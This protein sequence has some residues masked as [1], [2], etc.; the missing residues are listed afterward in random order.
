MIDD[1]YSSGAKHYDAAYSVKEDLVDRDFYLNLANEYGGPV[2]EFGCGTGRIT[3][4]LARQGV[5]V[6][7]LDASHSMLEVLRAKLAK[8]PA[9]VRRR[10]RVV[11]GDFR[12]HYLGDQ[13]S[14]VVIP[15][16]PMQHMYT[17]EDQLAA[18]QNA[19][20]HLADDG[21]L[22]FD[23][24]NPYFDKI[25]SGVGEEYLELEWPAQDGTDRMVRRYFV[26]DEI[27]LI[28]LNFSGRFIFRLCE[29]DK[30]L[31]EEAQ[32][33]KMSFYTYPH[34]KLLFHAAGLERVGEFGSFDRKPIGP[35]TPEMIFLLQ[36]RQ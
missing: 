17:T 28:N 11:E 2:L 19:R 26:K 33:L 4:P 35:E 3:L 15:F 6:T 13:F 23:V 1:S 14:L 8:E 36:R 5:D 7:G 18:L 16:R 20:R 30:V 31:S 10:T 12:T 22:A 25:L 24:F 9:G 34:L 27:D 29:G 32:P 21:I